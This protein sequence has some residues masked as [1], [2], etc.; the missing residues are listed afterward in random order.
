MRLMGYL[1]YLLLFIWLGPIWF[2]NRPTDHWG[3]DCRRNK[4][5]ELRYNVYTKTG[6]KVARILSPHSRAFSIYA[7]DPLTGFRLEINPDVYYHAASTFKAP[8]LFASV[9][10]M[11]EGILKMNDPVPVKNEFPSIRSKT[12]F[13]VPVGNWS[14]DQTPAK[15]GREVPLSFLLRDMIE[16]S[17]NIATNLVLEKIGIKDVEREIKEI[18]IKDIELRRLVYDLSA[19]ERCI[20]NMLSARSLAELY[21]T[22]D[23]PDIWEKESRDYLLET[24]ALPI[25]RETFP[26]LI[27]D[28]IQLAHKPGS[29]GQVVHDAGRFLPPDGQPYYLAV[30]T[31]YY[32]DKETIRESIAEVSLLI[33]NTIMERRG[34]SFTCA[35]PDKD[36]K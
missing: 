9:H 7:I 8:V 15:I 23:N 13:S 11:Q 32:D 34:S 28:D 27:T 33:C 3:S 18:G 5:G 30:M 36:K 31:A 16:Y 4:K 22:L 25:H 20:D 10:L 17:S 21:R 35:R 1:K 24:L 29:T 14:K 2:L 19:H 12:P 6:E 26:A